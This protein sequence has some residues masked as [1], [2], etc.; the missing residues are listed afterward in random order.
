MDEDTVEMELTG[1]QELG[2][3]Q[4]ATEAQVTGRPVESSSG[5]LSPAF[6]SLVYRR[7]ARVDFVCGLTL[8]VAAVG[9]TAATVW[10]AADRN[11]PAPTVTSAGPIVPPP[12]APAAPAEP[13]GPLVQVRNPFDATEV[14][15]F[16]AKTTKTEVREA[17][18]ELLLQRAR[19]RRG[20]GT[21]IK[22][23]GSRHP[24]RGAA[25]ERS[26]VFVTE[27]SGHPSPANQL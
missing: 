6:R 18:A 20:Q 22:H 11:P 24:A 19:E 2:L 15:E 25:D 3:W 12:A 5:S 7:T 1:E 16:P 21:G 4:A 14:F 8:A 10:P 26:D 9:V 17:M 27:L 23:A 13:Q